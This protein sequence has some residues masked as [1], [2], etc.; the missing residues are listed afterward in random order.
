MPYSAYRVSLDFLEQNR[1]NEDLHV[2]GTFNSEGFTAAVH[3]I[4]RSCSVDQ[5]L[6]PTRIKH[7]LGAHL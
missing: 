7:V 1:M 5:A 6:P 3:G 4:S 2:L